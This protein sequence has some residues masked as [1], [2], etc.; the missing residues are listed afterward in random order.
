MDFLEHRTEPRELLALP[1]K[2]GNGAQGLTHDISPSGLFFQICGAHDLSGTL[3]FELI[4]DEARMKFT[5]EGR[6]VRI[7]QR[8]GCTGFAVQLLSPRLEPLA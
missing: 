1:L 7:E 8:K 2:L 6:I 5:A 4:L 3:F